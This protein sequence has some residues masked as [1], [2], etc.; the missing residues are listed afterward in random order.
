MQVLGE[1]PSGRLAQ[2]E[3]SLGVYDVI[4][5]GVDVFCGRFH[6]R[7]GSGLLV[8][9]IKQWLLLAD[10]EVEVDH[11]V[12]EGGE[13]VAEA[14][15]VDACLVRGPGE[16]VI[17]LLD[18]LVQRLSVGRRQFHVDIVLTPRDHLKFDCG[19]HS[20]FNLLKETLFFAIRE[21][22]C[23][24]CSKNHGN[25]NQNQRAR[26]EETVHAVC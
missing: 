6:H 10:L 12:G 18:V 3:V 2:L 17:L 5:R 4:E 7:H 21:L 15:L 8:L 26:G 23:K 20:F 16:A 9:L 25:E 24:F 14:E 11:F 22:K 1:D 13:L 19:L